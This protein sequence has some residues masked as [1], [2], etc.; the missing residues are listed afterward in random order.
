MIGLEKQFEQTV[1][2]IYEAGLDASIW[3]RALTTL[4]DIL[5]TA[6][7]GICAMDR[8]AQEWNSIAPRTDPEFRAVYRQCWAFQNPL[9]TPSAARPLKEVFLLDDLVPREQFAASPIYNEWFRPAGFG[10]AMMAANLQT[11]EDVSSLIAVANG[12]NQEQIT[13]DQVQIFK[14]VLPHIDRSVRIHREFRIR[15]LDLYN[16]PDRLELVDLGVMLVDRSAR[17]LFANARARALL[18]VGGGFRLHDGRLESADGSD[19]L[20]RLIASCDRKLGVPLSPGGEIVVRQGTRPSLRVTV[21][22]LRARGTVP[23]LPWLGLQL[24]AALV[25]VGGQAIANRLH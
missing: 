23:E 6:H 16:A 1:S 8:R 9:W 5:N 2:S 19:A 18:R 12:L 17:V 21:T 24:P 14:R 13:R 10:L 11:S 15:D 22:P 3:P 4:A 7:I 25:T 20:Q